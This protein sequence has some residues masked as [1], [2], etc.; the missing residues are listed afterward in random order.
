MLTT[1]PKNGE[2]WETVPGMTTAPAQLSLA[3]GAAR[4]VD[5]AP[6]NSAKARPAGPKLRNAWR[7]EQRVFVIIQPSLLGP[8]RSASRNIH[9]DKVFPGGAACVLPATP[10]H[11]LC[12]PPKRQSILGLM[13]ASLRPNQRTD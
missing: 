1:G 9:T 8:R 5:R 12:R 4:E 3:G 6:T 7:R 2:A 13:L 11:M 10:E